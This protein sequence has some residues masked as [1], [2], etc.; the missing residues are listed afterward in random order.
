MKNKLQKGGSN[1]G[2]FSKPSSNTMLNDQL[3]YKFKLVGFR[4]NVNIMSFNSC[5]GRRGLSKS[6]SYPSEHRN[7]G[8]FLAFRIGEHRCY[9]RNKMVRMAR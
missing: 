5:E 1:P 9:P 8:R 3:S 7:S 4:F 6:C 2:P